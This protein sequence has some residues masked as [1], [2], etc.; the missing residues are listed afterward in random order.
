M[1]EAKKELV[2]VVEIRLALVD[3][4]QIDMGD[5]MARLREFSQADVVDVRVELAKA[6]R[7]PGER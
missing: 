7:K 1:S 5:A 2:V 6:E 4:G 3:I